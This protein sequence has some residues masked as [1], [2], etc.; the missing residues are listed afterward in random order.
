LLTTLE[1]LKP[2]RRVRGVV[3]DRAVTIV[4]FEPH[5]TE[6]ATLTYKD[7]A[8]KVDHQ[9][10]YQ[11]DAARYEIEEAAATWTFDADGKLFRLVSEALRIRLAYLF[12]PY[13]AV[14]TSNL[15]PLPHQIQAVYG[16]ML[17]RQPLRFILADD[18]G[19]GK[20]IMSGLL[21]KELIVR[22]DVR[23]CMVVVP[24]GLVE[25][26]QDE[27]WLKLGLDFEIVTRETIEASK[28]GNPF[29]EKSFVIARLDQLSRNS[30]VQAK[31]DQTEWDLI[32]V[33]EAHK[34]SAHYYGVE[35]KE[36]KRYHLG[37]QLG[38]IARHL[39]FLTA[40]PHSGKEED[41]QL[42]L[43]LI[44]PDR[45]E[46]KPRK[47]M[48]PL[49][50]E[51][52]M[53][54]LVKEKLLKFD[55]RPLFPER[56]AYT[57][58]YELSEPEQAL[59]EDVTAYVRE[60]MNRAEK[61][62]SEGEGR[63]GNV[64]GFALTVLQRRLAS[65]PE[66]IYQSLRRRRERLEDRLTKAQLEPP[67]FPALDE[68]DIE[69]FDDRPEDEREEIEEQVVDQA[70]AA[71][72]LEE[73]R[74]EIET[75][76]RLEQQAAHV[77]SLSTDK[78]WEELSGLLQD[79]PEMFDLEGQRRKLIV[80]T[81]HRDTL[82][83]LEDRLVTLLG[84]REAVVRI[85]GGMRRE[86]RREA[87]E[88]FIQDKDVTILVATDAAG[89]GVNLQ[90]AHLLVNYDLP[91]NPNR[92]EQRFGR[93]HRIGQTDVC[94]M[95][96]VVALDTREGAV[97]ERLF[98]KLK[99]QRKALGGQ[100]FDVLGDVFSDR[101]LRDL[102]IE[103]VRYGD[104]PETKARLERVVDAAV[105]E[106]L[107]QAV[108]ERALISDV[109]TPADVEE[110]R[111]RMEQAEA[112]RLQPHFIRSFFLEAFDRLGGQVAQ[113]EPGR[114]EIRHVP[115]ALRERGKLRSGLPV[116]QRYERVAFER[117]LVTVQGHPPAE[118]LAPGHPLLDVVVEVMLERYGELLKQGTVLVAAGDVNE[119]PRTLV[120]V[121]S[122]IQSARTDSAGN[123]A[124]VSRRL[125]F[126]ELPEEGE[127]V[128]AGYAP[129]LDYRALEPD[130]EQLVESLRS[131]G[132]LRE[133]EAQA[134]DYAIRRAVPEHLQE[135]RGQ[136]VERVIRTM[137]AVKHRLTGEI[138]YWDAR[139]NELKA[140][141]LAGKKPRL[142]SGKARQRAN[143]LEERMK[144]RL[145]ELEE[146]K[147]LAAL[148][149]VV[150]G[151]ALVLPEA[152]LAELG[153][154]P[155]E[156]IERARDTK[157]VERLAVEAVL[158]AER[159]LGRQPKEM[160]HNNPG[161][162][163]LSRDPLTG[164]ILFIEVKGRVAA[165]DTFTVTRNEILTALNKPEQ[166]V[167]ALVRVDGDETEVRY[168]TEP[169]VGPEE[170]FFDTASVNYRWETF[171]ERAQAPSR[172]VDGA[173]QK[174]LDIAVER[175]VSQFEPER[176]V[177]FGSHARGEATK[178][179]DLD[180]LVVM[181]EI[182][183]KRRAAVEMLRALNDFPIGVDV[184]PT[185]LHEIER[186]GDL[187]GTVLRPAL[188]EGRVV[189]ERAA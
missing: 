96:N 82:N 69:D 43:A 77:R 68:E 188:R 170:A 155:G 73:L 42:F 149:P 27:L 135:V 49:D 61:L 20:T 168:L 50:T 84:R 53:R 174:W 121:E 57:V 34:M 80:F 134:R 124:V 179:S 185:D 167:L 88:R 187:V 92:I 141:E 164:Q 148:P 154:V 165:A 24:G 56:V 100:V 60:E 152:A 29:A 26:W 101:S 12:D 169:F 18:P 184:I 131:R 22:G 118:L 76:R 32:V 93:I 104:Q 145:R 75:L 40:T 138:A 65:S 13:L 90:R 181:R 132:S 150:V 23:R 86:D 21:I 117:T 123:K 1:D 186:R 66:A 97:F 47:G 8:G 11:A 51:G 112:R 4:Q 122:A 182:K 28:S 140:Q 136:T 137:A 64:V 156:L 74:A 178:D 15:E 59:Y 189:F 183:D 151:G 108:T 55:G 116:L 106:K 67:P 7:D 16:E 58:K 17:P 120:Y 111:E 162:D 110:I 133:V 158:A 109:L 52:I 146:E 14:H 95:W 46:G 144:R 44:D 33:D 128:V 36:T 41:F 103:A 30:D 9:V 130:E 3:P 91:W 99:E 38:S 70:S 153:G 107:K 63:R 54:R 114:Y 48:T 115:A 83:Y 31:L 94:H 180:F 172:D 160:P 35:V 19:A 166:F 62:R 5:G 119:E 139:A 126:V 85:H 37:R 6:A 78:K 39:L 25:Q 10:V 71:R 79:A 129:Y 125:E 171:F 87:Q 142:N 72:T 2:G 176:I 147:E 177:L 98:E 157:R 159:R 102:L 161:Y 45:F 143:D 113:R 105:G 163:V 127:P 175:L 89:E 173:I 81:E